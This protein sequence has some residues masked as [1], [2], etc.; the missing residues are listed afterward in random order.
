MLWF[1]RQ[2][3]RKKHLTKKYIYT[4]MSPKAFVLALQ[5]KQLAPL[6]LVKGEPRTFPQ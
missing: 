1:Y 3:T 4:E 5:Q 6:R 2:Y